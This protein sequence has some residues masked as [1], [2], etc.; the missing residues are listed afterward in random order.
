MV[1]E[2]HHRNVRL[3]LAALLVLATGGALAE[4]PTLPD[5]L[6]AEPGDPMRGKAV[7]VNSD[8][9]NCVI[10]HHM[11]VPE[12]PEGAA[13]DIG[14]DL[15]GVGLRLTPAE[16]RQRVVNP[17]AI[18]PDTVMPAYHVATGLTRVEAEYQGKPILTAQQ[19]EDLIA[20]LQTLK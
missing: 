18:D 15:A 10:C 4:A 14:P 7:A 20:Y 1:P 16:L 9:G 2:H 11:P 17:K 13:G 3:T 6:T 5:P 8:M 12:L 19:V